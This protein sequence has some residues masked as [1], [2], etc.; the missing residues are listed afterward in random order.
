MKNKKTSHSEKEQIRIIRKHL[1]RLPGCRKL[2][3]RTPQFGF[4]VI[5]GSG[6]FG[7][8]LDKEVAG[9]A[10]FGIELSTDKNYKLI[11]PLYRFRYYQRI[12]AENETR[13]AS[14]LDE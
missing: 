6:D 3:I 4:M 8:F 7:R 1:K 5:R 14:P 11:W 12:M 9:L 13:T 2:S 10:E